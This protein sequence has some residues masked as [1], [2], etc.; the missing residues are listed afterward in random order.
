[1]ELAAGLGARHD[2]ALPLAQA[3]RR[4]HLLL[5]DMVIAVLP[6]K[7]EQFSLDCV[8]VELSGAAEAR[9]AF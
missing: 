3:G 6:E 1:M 8:S 4:R 5:A 7:P 2:R 9:L